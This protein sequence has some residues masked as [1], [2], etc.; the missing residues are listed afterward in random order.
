VFLPN[1]APSRLPREAWSGR[2]LDDKLHRQQKR[3]GGRY[4]RFVC[5][6][7]LPCRTGGFD[8]LNTSSRE[9]CVRKSCSYRL[10]TGI[11]ECARNVRCFCGGTMK[12]ACGT[13]GFSWY[14]TLVP[15]VAGKLNGAWCGRILPRRW[16]GD[17]ARFVHWRRKGRS[18]GRVSERGGGG[19]G[20]K[21]LL[22]LSHRKGAGKILQ[23]SCFQSSNYPQFGTQGRNRVQ[24][25]LKGTQRSGAS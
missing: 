22:L 4:G 18:E 19:R 21:A 2:D 8:E 24:R 12:S 9:T 3:G 7:M 16:R 17:G 11:Q 14:C 23:I 10:R 15:L 13:W 6:R 1:P 20:R 5:T 25:L